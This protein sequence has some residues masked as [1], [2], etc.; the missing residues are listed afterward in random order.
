MRMVRERR[1]PGVEHGGEADA[2]SE[3]LRVGGDGDE[4]L[5]GG[6]EQEVI[7]GGLVVERDRADRRRQGEDD[8]IVGGR[9]ELGFAVGEPLARRRA[10]TLRAVAVAARNGRRP[11]PALWADPVMGSWRAGIGIFR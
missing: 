9:Q 11:L 4:G 2:C 7:D 10:L 8:V 3:M 6:P 1:A 5:G